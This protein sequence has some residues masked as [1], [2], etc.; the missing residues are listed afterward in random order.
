MQLTDII[1]RIE[2]DIEINEDLRREYR[3]K[4]LEAVE[5]GDD[6][7]RDCNNDLNM[8]ASG[9]ILA[10]NKVLEYLKNN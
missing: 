10:L 8:M 9:E 5:N 7:A 3:E 4:W 1:S 2:R 6:V